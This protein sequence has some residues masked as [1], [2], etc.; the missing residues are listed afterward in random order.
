MAAV[1]ANLGAAALILVWGCFRALRL[2]VLIGD[3]GVVVRNFFRTYRLTWSQVTGFADGS[4]RSY[5]DDGRALGYW[6]L[7]VVIAGGRAVTAGG[8]VHGPP[9]RA[10]ILKAVTQ[11]AERHGI[12][13]DV[14][15]Q[16]AEW[17]GPKTRPIPRLIVSIAMF[18]ILIGIPVIAYGFTGVSCSS[19]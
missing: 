4:A 11:A 10:N 18:S 8:T 16:P 15:G 2:G 6:A 12:T 9:A 5:G 7:N 19:C 3:R 17:P 13:A 1:E 14:T